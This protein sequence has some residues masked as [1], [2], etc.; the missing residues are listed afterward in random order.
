ML[1]VLLASGVLLAASGDLIYERTVRVE[2]SAGQ[3][4]NLADAFIAVGAWDGNRADMLNC[5]VS[6][7][8][9]SPTGFSATC[10]GEKTAAPGSVPF[11][12]NV[13]GVE[14]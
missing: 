12:V 6:R 9:G 7:D 10:I 14:P 13:I 3:A 4:A 5:I 11:P 1:K 8:T 2:I